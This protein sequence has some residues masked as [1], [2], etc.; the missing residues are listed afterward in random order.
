MPGGR[1]GR[2]QAT[3]G[4]TEGARADFESSERVTTLVNRVAKRLRAPQ[5]KAPSDLQTYLLGRLWKSDPSWGNLRWSVI[6]RFNGEFGRPV[7]TTALQYL[8]ESPPKYVKNPPALL[9]ATCRA[10]LSNHPSTWKGD[11]AP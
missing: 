7:V 5:P 1:S 10:V 6:V 9:L 3:V 8:R 11:D 2:E 4:D